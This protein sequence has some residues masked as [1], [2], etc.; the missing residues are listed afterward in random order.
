MKADLGPA[1][2]GVA[3][4]MTLATN[5]RA[6]TDA[7]NPQGTATTLPQRR[8][9]STT[10]SPRGA[11]PTPSLDASPVTDASSAVQGPSHAHFHRPGTD[12]DADSFAGSLASDVFVLKGNVVLH[13]DPAVDRSIAD[14]S[15]SGDRLTLTAD[16]ID[17]DKAGL[18]YVAKGHV[19]FV[20]GLRSGQADLAQLNEETHTIDLIGN[21]NVLE[22]DHRAAAEKMHYNMADK[23]F[24][25]SGNVRIYEPLPTPNPNTAPTAAPKKKRRF[26]V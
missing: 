11:S 2:V 5:V 3:L 16:E 22:G 20:Q 4:A 10:P 8:V 13:S 15:Q 21:A 18:S 24:A 14:L 7:W 1:I 26:P 6:S 19:H 9:P 25:G 12:V 17:I 23:G